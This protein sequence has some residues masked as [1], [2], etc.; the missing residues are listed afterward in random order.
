MDAC[1]PV[2]LA[3]LSYL[4]PALLTWQPQDP[5]ADCLLVSSCM[6]RVLSEMGQQVGI[7]EHYQKHFLNPQPQKTNAAA[8]EPPPPADTAAATTRA[9]FTGSILRYTVPTP[10]SLAPLPSSPLQDSAQTSA[11][12]KGSNSSLSDLATPSGPPTAAA[13]VPTA[14][15]S[16]TSVATVAAA[17]PPLPPPPSPQWVVFGVRS[18]PSASHL[19]L[20]Q[21]LALYGGLMPA[22]R[23]AAVGF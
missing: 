7:I 10:T 14:S 4:V 8:V 5:A 11:S 19:L 23:R 21:L 9:S 2:H 6:A 16:Q 18:F 17:M 22:L 15:M 13:V 3:T 12:A 20:Y 1:E